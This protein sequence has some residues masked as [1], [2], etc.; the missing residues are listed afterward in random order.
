MDSAR[1]AHN[2]DDA[3]FPFREGCFIAEWW[4]V[5]DDAAVSVAR[6]RVEPGVTTRRHRLHGIAERYVVLEGEG[7]VE[8]GERGPETVGPGAVVLIPPGAVQR[9]TNHGCTDLVFLAVCTPRFRIECYEDV[10]GPRSRGS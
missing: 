4:N 7:C 2:D 1:I 3:E 9:I 10:D 5:E 8:V 6:A